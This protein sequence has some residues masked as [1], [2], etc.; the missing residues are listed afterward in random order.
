MSHRTPPILP[1]PFPVPHSDSFA[2]KSQGFLRNC[3][4]K[5]D[6]E[7]SIFMHIHMTR[8]VPAHQLLVVPDRG[9]TPTKRAI[10]GP[11]TPIRTFNWA[12]SGILSP[13]FPLALS[14]FLR[15]ITLVLLYAFARS[16]ISFHFRQVV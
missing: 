11:P 5:K 4:E 2:I 16:L 1:D 15:S 7:I 6:S 13:N 14:I 3:K 10:T 8:T 12:V 9:N